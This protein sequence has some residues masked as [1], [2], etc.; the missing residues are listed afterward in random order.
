M[1]PD[2]L[3][4]ISGRESPSIN[5]ANRLVENGATVSGYA[6][7]ALKTVMQEMGGFVELP[8]DQY[9][10]LRDADALML[11]TE[12]NEFREPDFEIM[13]QLMRDRVIFGGR[14]I[15]SPDRFKEHSF[16]YYCI[17]RPL[18]NNSH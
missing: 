6:P 1:D 11:V 7:K 16:T 17:G 3:P 8:N 4:A 15:W 9:E 12:L 10:V 13:K 14:N 2:H 18:V 5:I